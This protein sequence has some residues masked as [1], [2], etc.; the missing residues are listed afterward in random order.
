MFYD[1]GVR[2][3]QRGVLEVAKRFGYAGIAVLLRDDDAEV[4]LRTLLRESEAF[5][6]VLRFLPI[7]FQK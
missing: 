1:L 6:M 5:F 3:F 7:P 2:A 4:L